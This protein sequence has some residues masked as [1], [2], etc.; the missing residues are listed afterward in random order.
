MIVLDTN[1][2]SELMCTRSTGRV[3][4]WIDSHPAGDL[5]ISAVTAAELL[6]GVARLPNGRR[7]RTRE[8]AVAAVIEQDFDG[9][10][11]PFDLD[12]ARHFADICAQRDQARRPVG[13]ADAQVAAVCRA[14]GA[15]LATRNTADFT[16]IGVDLI[17]PWTGGDDAS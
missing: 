6:Y 11:L 14:R 13:T 17:D 4:A 2:V 8:D 12:A 9:R 15:A 7:K 3:L 10:V 16:G 5:A 1:V